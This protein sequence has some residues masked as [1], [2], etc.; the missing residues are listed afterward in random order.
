MDKIFKGMCCV[1]SDAVEMSNGGCRQ[2]R[3]AG[4]FTRL[5]SRAFVSQALGKQ[6]RHTEE[7][8]V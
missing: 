5:S 4:T 3:S 6:A 2:E 7:S 8:L 1:L